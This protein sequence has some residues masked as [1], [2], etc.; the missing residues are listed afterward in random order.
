MPLR[1]EKM[2]AEHIPAIERVRKPLPSRRMRLRQMPGRISV[3]K[4]GR[5]ATHYSGARGEYAIERG[6]NVG[7]QRF[8]TQMI[9][10]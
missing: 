2:D 8:V 10:G 5:A 1:H 7:V 9:F 6:G 4:S 3:N